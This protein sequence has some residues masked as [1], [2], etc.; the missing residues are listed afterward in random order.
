M[1][2]SELR[3]A[4]PSKIDSYLAALNRF[5]EK[6]NELLLRELV[7][8]GT[9]SIY[10]KW[11]S[12]NWNGGTYGHAVTLTVNE[13]LYF[14]VMEQKEDLQ[15]RLSTDLNELANNKKEYISRVFIEM[16]PEDNDNWREETGVYRPRTIAPSVAPETLQRIWGSK[17]I[18]VFLSHKAKFSRE[19][20]LVKQALARCEI[21][22]FLAH[23]DIEPTDEWQLE[24]ERALFSMDALVALLSE[25]FHE[26][27][28]TDQEIG[29]A[30]G[31][32]VPLIA[33]RLGKDP[34]GLM[35]KK[36]GLGGC[37]WKDPSTIAVN[38]FHLL[39]KRLSDK[40]RLF[41]CALAA[42]ERSDDWT[43]SAFNVKH[44]L[45][46][47][48]TLSPDQ[49]HRVI[50]TYRA[51]GQNKNSFDGRNLLRTLLEKWTGVKWTIRNNELQREEVKTETEMPF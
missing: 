12:D 11:D 34:Y 1:T 18:R 13:D 49:V 6:H 33:V 46:A 45:S 20:S 19:T 47:F 43:E 9:V 26:S 32:G 3:F 44:L 35:G 38:V 2:E 21:A 28:W 48:E 22:A 14:R 24:I 23:E 7:V 30:I 40:S 29:V 50:E 4:L 16:E 17:H 31:R 42:Y 15:T 39:H 51:N 41:E 36:Q 8:N 27:D 37:N 25:D 5:Y 10:E